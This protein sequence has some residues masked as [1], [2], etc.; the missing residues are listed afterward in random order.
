MRWHTSA[1]VL[2]L[3]RDLLVIY[4]MVPAVL[5]CS[6]NVLEP[7]GSESFIPFNCLPKR[8]L[9]EGLND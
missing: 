9:E 8:V 7:V 6:R 3:P 2:K 5:Q 1:L 4:I